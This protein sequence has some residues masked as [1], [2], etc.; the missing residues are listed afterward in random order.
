MGLG[1][2]RRTTNLGM[3]GVGELL[4]VC[5]DDYSYLEKH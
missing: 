4:E 2:L 1:D 5:A 3:R